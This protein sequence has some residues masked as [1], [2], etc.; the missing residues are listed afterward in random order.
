MMLC[1]LYSTAW[2]RSPFP[3]WGYNN[4]VKIESVGVER[5]RLLPLLIRRRAERHLTWTKWIMK[6]AG[7]CKKFAKEGIVSVQFLTTS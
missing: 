4:N 3:L 1:H 2:G 5:T 7:V 6:F